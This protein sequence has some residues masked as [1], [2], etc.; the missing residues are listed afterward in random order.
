[1]SKEV[2]IVIA[3]KNPVK[4]EATKAAF[5]RVFGA[6]FSNF[7]FI[8]KSVDSGVAHTPLSQGETKQ[9]ALNR[10]N[11]IQESFLGA[12]YFVAIEGG[13][14]QKQVGENFW[15][16]GTVLVSGKFPLHAKMEVSVIEFMLPDE[17]SK[18]IGD[19]QGAGSAADE[20]QGTTNSKQRGGITGY[21]SNGLVS[22][23]DAYFH[24]LVIAFSQLKNYELRYRC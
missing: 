10:L 20:L 13:F 14:Y 6:D 2:I 7:N 11:H 9:G 19:G 4:V 15:Q 18:K 3:S 8:E 17:L 24:P 23:Y 12:D 22:R 5:L 1:M 16:T 21:V